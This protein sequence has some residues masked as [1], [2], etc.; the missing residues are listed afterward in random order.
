MSCCGHEHKEHDH[1]HG[2]GCGH[3]A[4]EHDGHVDYLHDGHLHN[5]HGDHVD[6]HVVGT[7]GANA[8]ACTPEHTCSGHDKTH[9]HSADC[10]HETV[11]HGDHV[12]YLVE[13]HLHSPHEGHCDSH[14]P[15]SEK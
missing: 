1:K 9:Q 13:G 5:V 6:D 4:V 8:V 2:A 7:S 3:K 10:G 14:G 11:P 15:L 12:D